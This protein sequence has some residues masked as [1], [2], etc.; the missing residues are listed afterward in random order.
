MYAFTTV[1]RRAWHLSDKWFA[2]V[3]IP[4]QF[5]DLIPGEK[6]QFQSKSVF[7]ARFV[8]VN[9]LYFVWE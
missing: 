8:T 7:L 1:C 4:Q 5:I 6:L 2:L 3:N 9:V